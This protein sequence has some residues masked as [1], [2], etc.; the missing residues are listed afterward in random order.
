MKPKCEIEVFTAGC[1]ECEKT[2]EMVKRVAGDSC[3]VKILDMSDPEVAERARKMGV[4]CAPAVSVN[5]QAP[6]TCDGCGL[7]EDMLRKM[8]GK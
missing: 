8:L 2:I 1:P 5:G 6:V 4:R 7:D 3:N